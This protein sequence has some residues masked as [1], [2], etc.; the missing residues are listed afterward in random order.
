MLEGEVDAMA[1]DDRVHAAPRRRLLDRRRLRS[2]PSTT[3]A[4]G[5]V[6]WLETQSPQPPANYSY[7]FNRDWD[8]LAERLRT[9]ET[10]REP[11]P[12]IASRGATM[13][14]D[15][16]QRVD[17]PRLRR[18]RLE[19]ARGRA[20]RVRPRRAAAVRPEQHPLRHEHPHR[21]VGARQERPLRAAAARRRPGPVGLRLGG[22]APPA[23]R[24]VAAGLELA[25][26]RLEHARR[27]APADRRAGP[28]R[29]PHL[30]GAARARTR[31]RAARH[32]PDRHGDARL[33][34]PP[35]ASRPPTPSR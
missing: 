17:F 11:S 28:A 14:V 27:D 30:R 12:M 24:A 20:A 26:R 21:R 31:G 33:A 22:P 13:A 19:K 15:W 1:D 35:R 18:E 7:R 29:R 9:S 32:R 34:A 16:E 6:R 23:V 5:R 4:G 2:T 10:A 8:Y 25:G 3:R